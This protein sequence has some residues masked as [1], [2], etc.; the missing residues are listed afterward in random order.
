M[1]RTNDSTERTVGRVLPGPSCITGDTIR[2]MASVSIR[3][4]RNRGGAVVER[5]ERG[6]RLTI[7]RDGQPVAVLTSLPRAPAHVDELRRRWS[8]LPAVDPAGLRRDVDALIDPG[9]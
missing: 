3:D 4:L 5:A 9:L 8:R 1:I 7:T 6:E 2:C